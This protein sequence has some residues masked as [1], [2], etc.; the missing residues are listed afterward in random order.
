MLKIAFTDDTPASSAVLQSIIALSSLK[1]Y[2]ATESSQ[3]KNK[4]IAMLSA[5][6][7]Q[8]MDLSELLRSLAASLLLSSYLVRSNFSSEF[9]DT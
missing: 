2:G 7:K 5:S 1:L 6:L 8:N 3:S 4:A 9:V